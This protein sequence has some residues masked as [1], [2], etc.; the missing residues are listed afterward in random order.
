M[1][2]A[3][4][5]DM[6][7]V[8][9]LVEGQTEEQFVNHILN[10]YLRAKEIFLTAVILKS[11]RVVD[12]PDFRGGMIP[13]PRVKKQI[14]ELL[15]DCAAVAVTTMFDYYGLNEDFP[16][17]D[18]INDL[19]PSCYSRI[20]LLETRLRG[21]IGDFRFIPNLVL[22]EFES[23]LFSSPAQIVDTVIDNRSSGYVKALEELVSIKDRFG[24]PEMINNNRDTCPNRRISRAIKAYDKVVYGVLIAEDVGIETMKTECRHFREWLEHIEKL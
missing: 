21:D 7:R 16:G 10:P 2:L 1:C 12:G 8:L 11:K 14:L 19:P 4:G 20:E 3:E 24:N 22:H 6:K 18:A 23:L 5:R 9:A 17:M 13:Y 15:S